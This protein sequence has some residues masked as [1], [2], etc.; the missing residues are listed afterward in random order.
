MLLRCLLSRTCIIGSQVHHSNLRV[1]L[2]FC[3]GVGRCL[4]PLFSGGNQTDVCYEYWP[5]HVTFYVCAS[6]ISSFS[7]LASC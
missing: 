7:F 5:D 3:Q 6:L 4:F 2:I 1:L